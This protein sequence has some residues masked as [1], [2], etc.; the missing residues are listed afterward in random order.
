LGLVTWNVT[1][2]CGRVLELDLIAEETQILEI[3]F[4]SSI[5]RGFWKCIFLFCCICQSKVFQEFLSCH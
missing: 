2:L 4:T 3:S 5:L 1:V